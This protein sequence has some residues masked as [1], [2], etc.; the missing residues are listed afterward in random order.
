LQSRY[1][2]LVLLLAEMDAFSPEELFEELEDLFFA[3]LG[4]V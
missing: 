1:Y 4:Q 3:L 2:R